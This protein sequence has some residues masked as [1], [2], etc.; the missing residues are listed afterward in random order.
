MTALER[1]QQGDRRLT[2]V[3]GAG[4]LALVEVLAALLV[5]LAR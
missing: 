2:F 1:A 3:A 5:L 4:A